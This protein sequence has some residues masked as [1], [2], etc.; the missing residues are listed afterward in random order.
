MIKL[1]QDLNLFSLLVLDE[2][3]E[4]EKDEL[5]NEMSDIIFG[6]VL[7]RFSELK[8]EEHLQQLL[9]SIVDL[10]EQ[11]LSDKYPEIQEFINQEVY[12]FKKN[13]L[14]DSLVDQIDFEK[15]EGDKRNDE[16]IK[17]MEKLLNLLR[18]ES[19]IKSDDDFE[20]AWEAYYNH[21]NN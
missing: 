21:L 3:S 18:N 4:E 9:N 17:I 15:K 16:K 2:I 12:I 8:G 14:I 19:L 7:E 5:S 13:A 6:L 11:T 1:I 20:I 10:E